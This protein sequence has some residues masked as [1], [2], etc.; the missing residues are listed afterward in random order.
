M[1]RFADL[2]QEVTALPNYT[3]LEASLY[4]QIAPTTLKSWLFGRYY[5]TRAGKVKW[6]VLIPPAQ[7]H[8]ITL[9]SFVNIVE[10]HVLHAIRH[11]HNIALPKVR[12]ALRFVGERLRVPHPLVNQRFKTDGVDLFIE[13]L[14]DLVV[15]SEDGQVGLR[16]VFEAHLSRIEYDQNQIARRLYLFTRPHHEAEQP[17]YIVMDPMVSFGRPSIDGVPTSAIYDRYLAGDDPDCLARDYR[18][19]L[20]AIHEA[21]R[22]E[23]RA[24]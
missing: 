12:R 21:I 11:K 18:R 10:A 9:L 24:R 2:V 14:A 22:C 17:R 13:H 19:D 3:I 23:S 16:E 15:A 20:A 7:K 5:P 6:P 8:P 1:P 4:L